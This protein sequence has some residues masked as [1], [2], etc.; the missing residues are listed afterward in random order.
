[1]KINFFLICT[2]APPLAMDLIA[3][4]MQFIPEKRLSALE[5]LQ[6]PYFQQFAKQLP[7]IDADLIAHTEL[8]LSTQSLTEED[9]VS[10]SEE[11][12]FVNKTEKM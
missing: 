8:T 12:D 11:P 3:K 6:H 9:D 7:L 4:M 1:M 5:A 10:D 2:N